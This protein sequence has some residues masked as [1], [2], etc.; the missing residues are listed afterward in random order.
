M[1]QLL[2]A[3]YEGVKGAR[4]ALFGYCRTMTPVDL[5]KNISI[6]NDNS[7]L[8]LLTHIVNSYMHWVKF[9]DL[10]I[11]P[12]YFKDESVGDM[13]NVEHMFEQVDT[14]IGDFLSRYKT[15]Y[16]EPFTKMHPSGDRFITT[17]PLMLYTHVITHEFHHK[18]QILTMSRLL[19]YTPVDT[20]VIR[21]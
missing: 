6:F 13:D 21:T 11:P 9:F 3:Q 12:L 19:G 17:T 18:G 7:I 16:E 1:H 5:H 10:Q 4:H 2:A 15:A 20:D 8:M 14:A